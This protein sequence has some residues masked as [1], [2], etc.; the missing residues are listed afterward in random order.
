MP[1]TRRQPTETPLLMLL[2]L[3]CPHACMC[4]CIHV[5]IA[6]VRKFGHRS[7][8]VPVRLRA[9][10]AEVGPVELNQGNVYA[11]HI[12]R[13]SQEIDIIRHAPSQTPVQPLH[14]LRALNPLQ[15]CARIHRNGIPLWL[16]RR[17]LH[18]VAAEREGLRRGIF[19]DE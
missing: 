11:L 8:A 14:A 5:C 16:R 17:P 10:T 4:T 15:P 19:C 9:L 3:S 2:N 18:R 12:S 6:H 13:I 1:A 7:T